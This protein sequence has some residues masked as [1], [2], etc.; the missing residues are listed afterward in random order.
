MSAAL[1]GGPAVCIVLSKKAHAT[2]A[3]AVTTSWHW[4]NI[5]RW[6]MEVVVRFN[7]VLRRPQGY[8]KQYTLKTMRGDQVQIEDE[9]WVPTGTRLN[10]PDSMFQPNSGWAKVWCDQCDDLRWHLTAP[11]ATVT[12]RCGSQEII[13]ENWVLQD[14]PGETVVDSN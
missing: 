12:C 10:L 2:V 6:A 9:D 4:Q 8:L 11:G 7:G 13:P 1:P 5:K 14:Y 3:W